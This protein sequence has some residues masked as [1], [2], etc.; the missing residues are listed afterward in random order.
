MEMCRKYH[1]LVLELKFFWT[2]TNIFF[3][4]EKTCKIKTK[5]KLKPNFYFF[6]IQFTV[7]IR[8]TVQIHKIIQTLA[9]PHSHMLT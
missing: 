2:K 1:S 3:V 9:H 8:A 7:I 5:L 4:F 6:P